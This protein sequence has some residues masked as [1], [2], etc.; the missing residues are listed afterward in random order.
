MGLDA[1]LYSIKKEDKEEFIKKINILDRDN[2]LKEKYTDISLKYATGEYRPVYE[3]GVQLHNELK[4]FH[5]IFK[6]I[7]EYEKEY[8][9]KNP[10]MK[11]EDR[12]AESFIFPIS[13]KD[14]EELGGISVIDSLNLEAIR[15]AIYTTNKLLIEDAQIRNMRDAKLKDEEEV[16][17]KRSEELEEIRKAYNYEQAGYFRKNNI[18]H[19]QIMEDR[20]IRDR[21]IELGL[22]EVF[23]PPS[24]VYI[25]WEELIKIADKAEKVLEL[26]HKAIDEN[27]SAFSEEL[28]RKYESLL[29]ISEY[30][31][32]TVGTSK[33]NN[34]YI[35]CVVDI[36]R[37][38]DD[39][40]DGENK[41]FFYSY[42]Y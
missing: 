34:W 39:M 22:E 1:W 35:V 38:I 33:Y 15:D 14:S 19:N 5:R 11:K 13:E 4:K 23:T 16:Y 41:V 3:Y 12:P 27:K 24:F 26:Y 29:H 42:W 9:M 32:M 25:E 37:V 2:K 7:T 31:D 20:K 17:E 18:L 10:D 8:A 30:D 28:I 36:L 6:L 21:N 40:E